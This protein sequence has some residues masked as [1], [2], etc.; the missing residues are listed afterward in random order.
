VFW[1]QKPS[2]LCACVREEDT[3]GREVV[4]SLDLKMHLENG[5]PFLGAT[6]S[7]LQTA[8]V[9]PPGHSR[10]RR[11]AITAVLSLVLQTEAPNA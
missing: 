4:V 3:G 8:V 6:Q 1:L 10:R 11:L 2:I 7:P 9:C 5:R